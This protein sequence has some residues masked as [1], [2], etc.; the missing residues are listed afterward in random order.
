[1]MCRQLA[2]LTSSEVVA[3]GS[4]SGLWKHLCMHA[5]AA[6]SSS[7]HHAWLAVAAPRRPRLPCARLPPLVLHTSLAVILTISSQVTLAASMKAPVSGQCT[8][9]GVCGLELRCSR[10]RTA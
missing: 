7:T 2:A 5:E 6:R 10:L 4:L 8:A 3:G 9:G 1:M